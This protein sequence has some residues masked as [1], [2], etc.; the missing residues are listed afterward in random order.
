[1]EEILSQL[2]ENAVLECEEGQRLVVSALNGLAGLCLVKDEAPAAVERYR[3][4]LRLVKSAQHEEI[5]TDPLQ[6]L[7]TLYNLNEVLGMRGTKAGRTLED[8]KLADKAK[9]LRE[10]Y[11]AE[12]TANVC[13]FHTRFENASEEVVLKQQESKEGEHWYLEAIDVIRAGGGEDDLMLKLD[14]AFSEAQGSRYARNKNAR[15]VA[16]T[17]SMASRFQSLAGLRLVLNGDI[18]KLFDARKKVLGVVSKLSTE[19]SQ[20]DVESCGNC[21]DCKANLLRSGPRC[22][23]CRA[24]DDMDLYKNRCAC[25]LMN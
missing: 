24:Q 2:K 6:E 13:T 7:H 25:L 14:E 5:R 16:D 10:Q 19:P 9:T 21:G 8:G 20:Q 15:R 18:N 4:A 1:M 17:E 22:A 12:Q 23:H 11:C 3:E